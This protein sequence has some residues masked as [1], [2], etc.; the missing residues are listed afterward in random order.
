MNNTIGTCSNC[1]GPV[2][3]P[4]MMV[5]P[6]PSCEKCGA[7]P[8]APHGPVIPMGKPTRRWLIPTHV[9]TREQATRVDV[10]GKTER[11]IERT[12]AGM[13][14]NMSDDWFVDDITETEP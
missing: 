13:L 8:K 1:G 10:T 4:S 14:R 11:H 5:N 3:M 12:T 9:R 6:V 7:T 2:T